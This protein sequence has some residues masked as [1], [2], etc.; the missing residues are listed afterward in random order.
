MLPTAVYVI[1]NADAKIIM[2]ID[3]YDSLPVIEE[4]ED[5]YCVL[6]SMGVGYVVKEYSDQM[7]I[8]LSDTSAYYRPILENG[9]TEDDVLSDDA[10]AT[11]LDKGMEV[12]VLGKQDNWVIITFTVND[13]VFGAYFIPSEVIEI[14]Q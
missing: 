6:L 11:V 8:I 2:M 3:T 4:Y 12:T 7:G 5:F 1:P 10:I 13:E 9:Y 14:R